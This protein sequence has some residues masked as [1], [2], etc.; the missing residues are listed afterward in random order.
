MKNSLYPC[1]ILIK[2]IFFT[3]VLKIFQ[4]LNFMKIRQVGTEF[5]DDD[6]WTDRQTGRI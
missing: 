5:F 3:D 2:W 4:I 6:G 1:H